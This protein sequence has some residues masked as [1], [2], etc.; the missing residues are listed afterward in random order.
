MWRILH[1]N[2]LYSCHPQKVQG[3]SEEDFLR[4]MQFCR[5]SLQQCLNDP[6][7]FNRVLFTDEA[8]FTRDFFNCRNS[9]IWAE[10]NPHATFVYS[11]QEKFAVNLWADISDHLIGPY[12][13][14]PRLNRQIY[15]IFLE[16]TLPVRRCATYRASAS[17]DATGWSASTL[18]SQRAR[19]SESHISRTLDRERKSG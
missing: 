5:W 3:L 11:H 1:D 15:R 12:L 10:Y 14:P 2:Q 6:Y 13:L 18:Y 4:R 8:L 9:H 19:I 17:V 16:E 7:F